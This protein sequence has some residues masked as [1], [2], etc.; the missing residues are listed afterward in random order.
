MEREIEF[1]VV[2]DL[3]DIDDELRYVCWRV[4]PKNWI[5][6]IFTPWRRLKKAYRYLKGTTE[7]FSVEDFKRLKETMKT[8]ND[9]KRWEEEQYAIVNGN[10][11]KHAKEWEEALK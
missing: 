4:K 1:N 6:K 9:I 7:L 8:V 11:S 10:A 3:F 5:G 2:V